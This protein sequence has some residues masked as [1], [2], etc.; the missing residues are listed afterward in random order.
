M[1][2]SGTAW[3]SITNSA[4]A[5][6]GVAGCG[7]GAV[8]DVVDRDDVAAALLSSIGINFASL[9]SR[10]ARSSSKLAMTGFSS[11]GSNWIA[12]GHGLVQRG[13]LEA[14]GGGQGIW[15]FFLCGE[16]SV[17]IWGADPKIGGS[18]TTVTPRCR[19]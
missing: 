18:D 19:R 14:A 11:S 1:E 5:S 13:V 4:G 6:S 10:S 8:G 3:S 12:D 15:G 9:R 7:T 2:S 16:F 17:E